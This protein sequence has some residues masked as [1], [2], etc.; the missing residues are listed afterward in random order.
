MGEKRTWADFWVRARKESWERRQ[1]QDWEGPTWGEQRN[2]GQE[3]QQPG[4][5]LWAEKTE[6]E[7]DDQLSTEGPV[8]YLNRGASFPSAHKLG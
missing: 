4:T 7:Q 6:S 5:P 1:R 8:G 2:S 3:Q